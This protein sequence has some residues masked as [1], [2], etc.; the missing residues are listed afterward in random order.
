MTEKTAAT[1]EEII[2]NIRSTLHDEMVRSRKHALEVNQ[3][4]HK[5]FKDAD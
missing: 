4:I 5:L 1:A 2:G 3:M